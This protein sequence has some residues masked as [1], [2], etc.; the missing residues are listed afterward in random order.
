MN[1]LFWMHQDCLSNPPHEAVF[2]FDDAQLL[3]DGWGLKRVLF[4]YECLLELP[5]QL[6]RGP[7]IATLRGLN[8]PLVTVASPDPWLRRI[9]AELAIEVLPA[10]CFVELKEPVDL[11][12]FA[13]YWKRAEDRLLNP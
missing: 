5:V 9:I 12:R 10:P 3:A 7:T 11:K 2:V 13:R 6:L 4:V 8:R 1:K